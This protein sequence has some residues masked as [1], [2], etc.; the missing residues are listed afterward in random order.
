M[1][2]TSPPTAGLGKG[3]ALY[4]ANDALADKDAGNIVDQVLDPAR[5]GPLFGAAR[6]PF[7][8]S[9][10]RVVAAG[11]G[12]PVQVRFAAPAGS[13][14]R[15]EV[16]GGTVQVYRVPA[17]AVVRADLAA[18]APGEGSALA[19]DGAPVPYER[20]EPR[21]QLALVAIE[22]AQ[23]LEARD[24]T[25]RARVMALRDAA[26]RVGARGGPG[27]TQGAGRLVG[28]IEGALTGWPAR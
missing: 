6:G 5:Y 26:V 7:A 28:M 27:V 18:G 3:T 9:P 23:A 1:A 22:F 13:K 2:E 21:L 24:Q 10:A 11:S 16:A 19:L 17:D 12:G 20:A 15:H 14:V 8:D 4:R 25:P